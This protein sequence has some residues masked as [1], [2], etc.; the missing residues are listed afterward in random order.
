MDARARFIE[1][2]DTAALIPV[3]RLAAPLVEV[4]SSARAAG[5]PDTQLTPDDILA[6]ESVNDPLPTRARLGVLRLGHP[7]QR[8]RVLR[9]P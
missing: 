7:P 4:D 9:Q 6:R 5:N 1:G 8:S 2:G 3:D